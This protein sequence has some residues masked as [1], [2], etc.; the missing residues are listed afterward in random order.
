MAESNFARALKAVL[1]HEGGYVDH[2]RDPGG[3]TNLGI[4]IGTAKSNKMDLDRD[5]DVD[6]ADVRLI[7]AADAGPVYKAKYWDAVRGD[8]MPAGLD[9]ALFDYAVNSG[10]ARAAIHLQEI[11]GVA[12]DGKI[13]ALTLAAVAKW[14]TIVLINA[15]CDRRM[16]FL[17]KLST[18]S[19]FGKGW[20]SRV[21]GVIRLA[22][23]MAIAFPVKAPA[24]PVAAPIPPTSTSPKRKTLSDLFKGWFVQQATTKIAS[25]IVK[26]TKMSSNLLHNLLNVAIAIVAILSLP[27][28]VGILPP[29]I[30]LAV[31]GG[32]GILKTLINIVR[33]GFG[34]LFKEQPPVR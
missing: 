19:T 5:G 21:S 15:L 34:G 16:A 31:A 20:S 33:D 6:K 17:K 18:W 1:A 2:P 3:A 23:D 14:D 25:T 13:G 12:P 22:K 27:E 9:Y 30:G 26:E 24:K 11:L 28:V 10:P 29:D 8:D 7:K 4:T 32:V